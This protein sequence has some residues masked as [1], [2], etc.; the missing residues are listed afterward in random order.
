[1]HVTMLDAS[2][3]F[4]KINHSKLL[5]KLIDLLILCSVSYWYNTQKFTVRW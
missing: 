5:T 2:S 3:A 4:A 1:M